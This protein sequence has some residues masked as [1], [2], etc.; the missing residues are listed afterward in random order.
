MAF[1]S[2]EYGIFLVIV[3]LVYWALAK[4][5]LFRIAFMLV[6]SWV[7]YAASNPYFLTLI[8]ASTLCDYFAGLYIADHDDPRRR[9][10]ALIISLVLN[11]GLLSV[12]KYTNF[13]LETGVGVA[14]LFGADIPFTRLDILLPAGISFYTFQTMSYTIDVYRRQCDPERNFIKFAF[15][16]G[17]FPQLVAGPIVRAVDFLPQIQQRPYFTRQQASRALWLIG[18]GIA[19]KVAIADV[20]GRDIVQRVFDDPNVLSSADVL[21][22]LYAYTMQIYMDFSAY[23]DIAIGSAILFGYKLPDNFDRPYMATSIQDFW[24]RWHKTLGS[25]LR[26]YIYYPLGGGHGAPA[27]VYR[28]LFITFLLIGLWHGADWTFVVYGGLHATAMCVNRWRR[29]RAER[30]GRV[31]ET[32]TAW[33]TSWRVFLTLHF[34]VLARI[35][36]RA[37]SYAGDPDVVPFDKAGDVFAALFRGT[38]TDV[39]LTPWLIALLVGAYLWH[40]TPRAWTEA[41]FHGF[42]RLPFL[43]QGAIVALVLLAVSLLSQGRPPPFMYMK[44]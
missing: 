10:V 8:W 7:F 33:G 17:F 31:K 30:L 15:F 23:S 34:V 1:N 9:K 18:L 42:K 19:K 21:L 32:F 14:N 25:W 28:N 38:Y 29:K 27:R 37:G 16:V 44:F 3:F 40:W 43:A 22:G 20:L 41:T 5:G 6:A 13:F 35:L 39:T 36:F 12:F 26:D 11:L 4:A 24:R 2:L